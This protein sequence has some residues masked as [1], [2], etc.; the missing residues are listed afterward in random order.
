MAEKATGTASRTGL[1]IGEVISRQDPTQTGMV[2]V[3]WN[4]GQINQSDLK[5]EDLPWS[6]SLM[7]RHSA[8]I[9]GMGGPHTGYLAANEGKGEGS[10]VY[11][12]SIS[13]DGQDFIVIGSVP[14]GGSG[15]PDGQP[16]YNSDIPQ[17]AKQQD[18]GG[19]SQPRYGDKNGVCPDYMNESVIIYAEQQGGP[20]HSPAKYPSLDDSAGTVGSSDGPTGIAKNNLIEV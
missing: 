13:G 6:K 4:L 2:K 14:S 17:P 10:K 1:V 19:I 7:S 11:G 15:N 5:E 3:R 8:S 9:R 18:V 16:Q 12:I 20:E